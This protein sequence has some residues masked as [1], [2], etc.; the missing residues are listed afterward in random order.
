[1]RRLVGWRRSGHGRSALVHTLSPKLCLS[2]FS[3]VDHSARAS[4]KNAVR[5]ESK[6]ELQDSLIIDIS[7][8]NGGSRSFVTRTTPD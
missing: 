1:M 8:A 5:C 3:V 6:C 2:Q 4:M 7:N